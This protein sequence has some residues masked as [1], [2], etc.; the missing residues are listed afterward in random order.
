MN[1]PS[2]PVA[3]LDTS[4]IVKW[5]RREETLANRAIILRDAYLDGA[6]S[7]AEPWLIAYELA[8]VLRYKNDWTTAQAQGAVQSILGLGFDWYPPNEATMFRA[9]EIARTN[10]L[11]VYDAVPVALAEALGAV[12][13]TAD[14]KALTRLALFSFVRSLSRTEF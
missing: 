8:N 3:I 12:F 11:A 10:D 5:F 4:V 9:V 2:P 1:I 6:I 14:D 13:I 7:I